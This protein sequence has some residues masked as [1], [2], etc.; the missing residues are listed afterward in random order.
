M[1]ILRLYIQPLE[2]VIIMVH[3]IKINEKSNSLAMES[4]EIWVEATMPL[5]TLA[6]L[7]MYVIVNQ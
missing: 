5:Q 6:L 1:D 4:V 3:H 7:L 2:A